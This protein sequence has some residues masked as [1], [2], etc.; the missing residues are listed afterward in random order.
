MRCECCCKYELRETNITARKFTDKEI[1]NIIEDYN[2]GMRPKDL[3]IKYNR[4]PSSIINKL[5]SI[6]KYEN[7]K[8]RLYN[9]VEH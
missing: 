6:G 2:N 5:K 9:Q 1:H 4:N 8:G 3:G 7:S